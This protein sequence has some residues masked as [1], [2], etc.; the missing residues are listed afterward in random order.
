MSTSGTGYKASRW[1]NVKHN[2]G[3]FKL[4]RVPM[5]RMRLIHRQAYA[6]AYIQHTQ[7]LGTFSCP[8]TTHT[9]NTLSL[10]SVS[11]EPED[12]QSRLCVWIKGLRQQ[13]TLPFPLWQAACNRVAVT[14]KINHACTGGK[15]QQQ[16][17]CLTSCLPCVSQTWDLYASSATHS[18]NGIRFDDEIPCCDILGVSLMAVFVLLFALL[19]LYMHGCLWMSWGVCVYCMQ[20]GSGVEGSSFAVGNM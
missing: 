18:E 16:A 13:R 4:Q 2:S 10:L 7:A 15:V 14:G 9:A 3:S 6:L 17:P 12:R 11:F 8:P 5:Y 20:G 19:F 1:H